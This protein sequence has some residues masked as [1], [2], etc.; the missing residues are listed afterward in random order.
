MR[1]K[2]LCILALL[3][4]TLLLSGCPWQS[5]ITAEFTSADGYSN[6]RDGLLA[7]PTADINIDGESS[8]S[9]R[10]LVE[11]D[12]IRQQG[13]LLYVLNQ[14][15]GLTIVDMDTRQVLSQTPMAGYPRDLYIADG[16]AYILVS[17]AQDITQ[18]SG[19]LSVSYG[20]RIYVLNIE[21]PTAISQAGSF[22]FEGD[23]VDSRMVG[24]VIYAVCSDYTWYETAGG[25]AVVET[26]TAAKSYGSTWAVS[27]NVADPA[28]IAVAD[29]LSFSGY[30]NLIQATNYAIFSVSTNWNYNDNTSTSVVNYIDI[31]DPTGKIARRGAAE[32]PGYMAD[33]FKMD[34]WNGALRLVTNTGWPNR[35]TYVTTLDI[36]NP[37]SMATLGGTT[38]ESA[39]GETLYATRFDGPLAYIVTYLTVDPLFVVDLSDPA[40]PQV[41]GELKIP[42]WSTHIEPRGDRLIA[43]GV[44]DADGGRKVMVSLF[45]VSVPENPQRIAYESFGDDWSWSSAYGDIKAFTV[46]DDM[47]LIPF[48]GW[49]D[50][51]G[52]YNRLQFVSW[53]RDALDAKGYVDLQGSVVRSFTHGTYCYAVTQEQLAVIDYADLAAPFLAD[54]VTLAENI[55]D[56][57]PLPNEWV[58]QVIT[59]NDEGDTEIGAFDPESGIRGESIALPLGHVMNAFVWHDAV[60]LAGS[61]YTYE[62][63]YSASYYVALVD[64]SVPQQPVILREWSLPIEPWWGGWYGY[65]PFM[66]DAVMRPE[67]NVKQYWG[68]YGGSRD[69]VYLAGDY[70]MLRCMSDQYDIAFGD[71]K[72][73]QGMAVLDLIGAEPAYTIGLGYEEVAAI[74]E[75]AGLA[76]ITSK[77]RVGSDADKRGLCA[78]YLQRFNPSTREMENA[79]N[80]PGI[81]LERIPETGYLIFEDQQYKE[82]W[83]TVTLL[84]ST[85]MKEKKVRLLDSVSMETGYWNLVVEN[86]RIWYA[87]QHY[88]T[89]YEDDQSGDV[90]VSSDV[91]PN[92]NGAFI[93]GFHQVDKQGNFSQKTQFTVSDGWCN[94][95]GV[96]DNQACIAVESAAVARCDF[97]EASPIIESI[98]PIMG[99][100]EKTRFSVE[101]AYVSLGYGGLTI[102]PF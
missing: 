71:E 94:L 79:V 25:D 75:A 66:E 68:G 55:V 102:L 63:E 45:D 56:A 35:Q 20:S 99:Y 54:S 90:S 28:N 100:P 85:E 4:A 29:T 58:A 61:V 101:A 69:S 41:K 50:T 6:S 33:R 7:G 87:G 39:S 82:D 1:L 12:V 48:S 32:I 86:D 81:F 2:T 19:M 31:T 30:G 5:R 57:L 74:Q 14:Y 24:S 65:Y 67:K 84:R 89:V 22:S 95:L 36:S 21:N 64:F 76:Y 73:W 59:R 72:P 43:L 23:L 88:D 17:Y 46:M 37:D 97:R 47:L 11:P 8:S 38:L 83:E 96:K 44:D 27:F 18:E 52:V 15:R 60:V 70:L 49:N 34:A 78:Y 62:P 80:V 51:A 98:V 10:E 3:S 77:V 91:L 42:G 13:N 16:R 92:Y 40:N 26:N 93:L 53:S 9:N